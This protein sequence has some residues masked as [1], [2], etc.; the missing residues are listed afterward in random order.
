MFGSKPP[1]VSLWVFTLACMTAC[2]GSGDGGSEGEGDGGETV[3][4]QTGDTMAGGGTS[5]TAS[6]QT[7]A[8]TSPTAAD[9]TGDTGDTGSPQED[10]DALLACG[11]AEPCGPLVYLEGEDCCG[12]AP[13]ASTEER[14]I[15]MALRDRSSAHI[16]VIS[17]NDPDEWANNYTQDDLFI[18]SDGSAT[19]MSDPHFN[20]QEGSGLM[21]P[22]SAQLVP[23]DYFDN[24]FATTDLDELTH[25]R[26]A[27]N[28]YESTGDLDSAEC[29]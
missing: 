21:V 19:M 1:T 18:W 23:A 3:P 6:G 5:T 29:L 14:C 10:K 12:G 24:C 13:E 9:D 26:L 2:G 20:G 17:G 8:D 4:A 15:Y 7:M 22:R 27:T 28:W 25:C 16:A 11:L